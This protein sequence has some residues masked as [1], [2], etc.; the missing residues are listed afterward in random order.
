MSKHQENIEL[1]ERF[2][3]QELTPDEM[4]D[5]EMRVKSDVDFVKELTAMRDLFYGIKQAARQNLKLELQDIGAEVLLQGVKPYYGGLK[6]W[7]KWFWGILLGTILGYLLLANWHRL[8]FHAFK[9]NHLN[10]DSIIESATPEAPTGGQT[11]IKDASDSTF[12][13]IPAD[14][15]LE[16]SDTA[17][18]EVIQTSSQNGIYQYKIV[19]PQGDYLVN[20]PISDLDSQL[21]RRRRQ[22]QNSSTKKKSES[23][24]IHNDIDQ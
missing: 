4:L 5:F 7:M 24:V 17:P 16:L 14:L 19:T 15:K 20:S 21:L 22:S 10:G 11:F 13:G 12:N 6:I 3:R 8:D 23:N 9:S 1:I 18:L 2:F